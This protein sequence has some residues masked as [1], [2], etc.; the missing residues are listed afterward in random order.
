MNSGYTAVLFTI[1]FFGFSAVAAFPADSGIMTE[2]VAYH[3]GDTAVKGFL[4]R[5]DDHQKHPGIILIHEWWGLDDY[6]RENAEKFARLGYVALA[7]D[8]YAGK[9]TTTREEARRLAAGVRENTDA[10]F[11]NLKSAVAYLKQRPDVDSDRLAAIGWCFGGG[12]S[13]RMAKNNLGVKASVIYYGRFNFTPRSP[14][15]ER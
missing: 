2:P 12:W 13:Y 10:A 1:I 11:A 9:S 7:V 14:L 8:M 4:A 15:P 3:P 6:I 5:P